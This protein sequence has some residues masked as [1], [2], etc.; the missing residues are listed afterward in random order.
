MNTNKFDSEYYVMD[1]DYERDEY[2]M[3]AWGEMDD[4]PFLDDTP[5]DISDL[6]FPLKAEFDEPYPQKICNARFSEV[7]FR[8]CLHS[9]Y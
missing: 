7:E 4:T 5:I 2:P 6:E 9:K 1:I 8:I 3:L